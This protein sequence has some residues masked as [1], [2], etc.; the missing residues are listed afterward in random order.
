MAVE[1]GGR[2]REVASG[3]EGTKR[4]GSGIPAQR[5]QTAI[6][7]ISKPSANSRHLEY[8][9]HKDYS[10]KNGHLPILLN[11]INGYYIHQIINITEITMP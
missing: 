4:P 1:S 2:W 6:S 8:M 3:V 9:S 10:A 5:E 7:P 11:K